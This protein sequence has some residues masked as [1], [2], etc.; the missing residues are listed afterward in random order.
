MKN[1]FKRLVA[2]PFA[3]WVQTTLKGFAGN[4]C[5]MHAAGL[6]YFSML[7]IVPILCILLLAARTLQAE[8]YVRTQIDEQIEL[9]IANIERG[10]DD[11]I[12]AAVTVD[13]KTREARR[14]AAQEF[15]KQAREL[16]NQLFE[17]IEQ[18]DVST[19]GWV[20]FALL[21][22][23][24]VSSMSM[25][26]VSMNQI[27][28]VPKPRPV[29]NRAWLY[30]ALAIVLPV[31]LA[32]AMS[33]PVLNTIKNV[34]LAIGE[35]SWLTQTLSTGLIALLDSWVFRLSITLFF[36]SVSFAFLFWV[37]PN[38]AVRFKHACWGGLITAVLFGSWLKVCAIAQVGI[39]NSSALYGSFALL[40]IILAWLYMS[41]QILLLGASMVRA[42]DR[43]CAKAPVAPKD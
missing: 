5:S 25:V 16:S 18:F 11:Q 14:Q 27:W 17:K 39:A 24:V 1:L 10:Q 9:A 13:E 28:E 31:L 33:L 41:W 20:G 34:I 43:V 37:L 32:L 12:A 3:Q 2:T 15:G 4:N 40:P 30:L 21:L 29:W 36:S 23:S 7:A 38:C 42:F 22:W 6:T 8:R 19:L 35:K 26:E